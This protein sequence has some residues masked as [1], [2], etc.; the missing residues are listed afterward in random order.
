[1]GSPHPAAP[2]WV[3]VVE[4]SGRPVLDIGATGSQNLT[5]LTPGV[6]YAEPRPAHLRPWL[7]IRAK[8][9]QEHVALRLLE[10]RQVEAYCPMYQ[11]PE[12]SRKAARG[13]EPLFPGYFFARC[14]DRD[15]FKFLKYCPG[16]LA[17]LAF[18]GW[19]ARVPAELVAELRD[20]EGDRGFILSDEALLGLEEGAP[21]EVMSG[22]FKGLSGLFAGY[23]SGGQRCRVLLELVRGIQQVE[24]DT[25]SVGRARRR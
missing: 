10:Q 11:L 20:R 18:D 9:R 25:A 1:M 7:V 19:L 24:L 17:P 13:P 8:S 4:G 21:V 22:P 2:E 16:V 23:K 12:F 15:E 6:T 14:L 3:W 5:M